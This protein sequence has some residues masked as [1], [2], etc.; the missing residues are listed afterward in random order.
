MGAQRDGCTLTPAKLT[1]AWHAEATRGAE[2]DKK[3]EDAQ[4]PPPPGGGD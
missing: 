1:G 2:R 4:T 3:G